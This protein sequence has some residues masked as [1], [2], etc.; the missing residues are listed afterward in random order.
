M[1]HYFNFV[2]QFFVAYDFNPD[3]ERP[4]GWNLSIDAMRE[5]SYNIG[6]FIFLI[7]GVLVFLSVAYSFMKGDKTVKIKKGEIFLLLWIFFG[8]V[9]AIVLGAT[10]LLS[11]FLL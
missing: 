1:N 4:F 6:A 2:M 10:Q 7:I 8:V 5:H 11:G 3:V 9:A